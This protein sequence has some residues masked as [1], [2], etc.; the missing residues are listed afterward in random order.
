M[1]SYNSNYVKKVLTELDNTSKYLSEAYIFDGEGEGMP[2]PEMMH[3]QQPHGERPMQGGEG[4]SE[5]EQAL[6]AQ[7]VI[8]HE[9]IVGKIRETAIDGLK[10]YAEHPTSE[11]YKF[12]KDVFLSS[13]KLL[14]GTGSK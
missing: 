13:D 3:S 7:E 9:P 1:K 10:K 12:F 5:E 4:E 2:N 14:T 11:I 6:H 8:Q